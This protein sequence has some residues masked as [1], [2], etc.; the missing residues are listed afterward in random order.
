MAI[1]GDAAVVTADGVQRDPVSLQI[2]Y[3]SLAFIIIGVGFLKP[4][5]SSIVGQLYEKDDPRRDGGFT[6]FYMGINLGAMLAS[7]IVGYLGQTFGWAYGFGLAGIGMLA[8]LIT[9]RRGIHLLGNAG[10]PSD[11]QRLD[12]GRRRGAHTRAIDLCRRF[13]RRAGRVAT[14]AVARTGRRSAVHRR[15]GDR[16]AVLSASR[17]C[18]CRRST[19]TACSSRCSLPRYRWSS[20]RFSNRR[21]VR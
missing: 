20:G 5:I 7:S 1:E 16:R 19:A 12:R 4:N 11:A 3:A 18:A 17:C 13:D 8:G 2:F 10:L 15:R 21:A 9:F 14:R 6:Y